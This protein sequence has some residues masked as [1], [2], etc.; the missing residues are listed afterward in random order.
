[1]Y[2]WFAPILIKS[3]SIREPGVAET[4]P[5][6]QHA[7]PFGVTHVRNFAQSLNNRI[8]VHDDGS[9]VV[10]CSECGQ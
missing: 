9:F 2:C 4:R 7:P 1:M 6:C 8:V 3:L 10:D 5:D